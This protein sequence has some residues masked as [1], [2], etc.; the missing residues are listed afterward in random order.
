MR[1]E[2]QLTIIIISFNS[3]HDIL[4]NLEYL[5]R[6]HDY[7]PL[8]VLIVENGE[9]SVWENKM[10][11]YDF[12]NVLNSKSNR[13]FAKANNLAISH[14]LTDYILFLNPDTII[15]EDF[16]TPIISFLESH[17][18]I[19]AC[20]PML[21]YEN[22]KYQ[23]STGFKMGL[24]YEV[25]E[26]FMC[27]NIYR[28]LKALEFKKKARKKKPV[29][30]GWVSGAC[31][32]MKKSVFESVGG[33]DEG[34]FLNYEDIDLC[35]KLEDNG[36][37]N[38]YFPYLRCIHLDHKSFDKYYDLLVYSRYESRLIYAKLNYS[39]FKRVIVRAIHILG[40]MFRL[41]FIILIFKGI[42][43]KQRYAGYRRSLKLYLGIT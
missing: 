27:I 39:F 10:S 11:K 5:Q 29:K 43:R 26:A 31:M 13:G 36:Y 2:Q 4:K 23:S 40:I 12:I 19:G 7:M 32:I 37:F 41:T 30:V 21:T 33:F 3:F 1:N 28:F 15:S 22:G 17:T 35:R 25:M 6:L 38:F 16:I 24:V 8:K 14:C 42:E 9:F 20:A 18:N 34:Y